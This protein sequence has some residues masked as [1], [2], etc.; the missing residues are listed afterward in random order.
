MKRFNRYYIL[1]ALALLL[2]GAVLGVQLDSYL[3]DT[4]TFAELQKLRKAF[5]TINSNYVDP[6]DSE[7]IAEQGIQGMLDE[8]DPHSSYIKKKDVQRV[9]ESYEGSFGGI[10]IMFEMVEDTARVITPIADG[11]SDKVGVMSGDRI[12]EIEDSTAVGLDSRGIQERLK[13]P[14]D[15][16]VQMTV[17]RPGMSRRYTFTITRDEIPLYSI[18]TAYMVDDQTG[19]IEID[20]FAMTTHDEF[21]EKLRML[22]GEGM[23]RLVLD[24]RGNHGGVMRSAIEIVDELLGAGL[25]ILKTRGRRANMNNEYRA[26]SGGAFEE[27]PVIVLVDRQSASASE[28]VTGALQ[29]HDRALVVGQR[30]FGKALV[31]KQ[32]ELTDGS[33]LQMTVGRYY[34][35]AGRLIQTPYDDGSQEDYYEQKFASMRKA[36]FDL[37]AYKETIPDSLSYQTN[38]GRTVYGG[39]GI[40]PDVVVKP[41][42]LSIRR[43]I[44]GSGLDLAFATQWFPKHEQEVRNQWNEREDAFL[45]EY[46]VPQAMVDSFWTYASRNGMELTTNPDSAAPGNGVFLR[47]EA[48]QARP[49]VA[50]RLKALLARQL[51]GSSAMRPVLNQVDPAFQQAISLWGDANSLAAY[52]ASS[53]STVTGQGASGGSM[54]N[55]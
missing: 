36:T 11:P 42:T 39:G 53:E 20:R 5:V 16:E 28:I 25:P 45:D 15:T 23:E 44:A 27:Q 51:Y 12:V 7:A 14:V 21:M 47:A 37:D 2:L 31:Q 26:S 35:P 9:Q 55:N 38:H 22:K 6:V 49:Y 32:F 8:L 48:E 54:N 18:N 17:Y 43:F 41:D 29:D 10:G 30:T 34:T 50:T 1:P 52:H 3:S 46:E 24:L 40:L 19:Y 4:D 13:G 33:L